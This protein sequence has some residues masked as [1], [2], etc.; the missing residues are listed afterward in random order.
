MTL[1]FLFALMTAA[2]MF[3]VLWPL[4]RARRERRTGGDV[5]VYRDQIDEI[6]RDRV[7]PSPKPGRRP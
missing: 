5:A 4:S 3:A 1:W 2:A 6:A 7:V